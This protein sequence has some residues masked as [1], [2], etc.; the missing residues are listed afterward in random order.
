MR[1]VDV[2]DVPFW[3]TIAGETDVLPQYVHRSAFQNATAYDA[4]QQSAR[5]VASAAPLEDDWLLRSHR[6]H[7]THYGS[8]MIVAL[9]L[10]GWLAIE[11]LPLSPWPGTAPASIA[12]TGA[13][14]PSLAALAS[15]RH[16]RQG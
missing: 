12:Q 11:R 10:L 14:S 9:A 16:D 7:A 2:L 15:S 1:K 13:T 3:R 5:N 4:F 8:A 6:R